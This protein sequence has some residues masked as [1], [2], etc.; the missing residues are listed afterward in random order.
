MGGTS[1]MLEIK[2]LDQND[3]SV[4]DIIFVGKEQEEIKQ[5]EEESKLEELKTPDL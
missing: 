2:H 1:K 3:V 5:I 4:T